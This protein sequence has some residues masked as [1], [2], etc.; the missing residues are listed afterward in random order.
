MEKLTFAEI[1]HRYKEKYEKRLRGDNDALKK[2]LE[3]YRIYQDGRHYFL[4]VHDKKK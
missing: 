3:G 4:E 2:K 1:R